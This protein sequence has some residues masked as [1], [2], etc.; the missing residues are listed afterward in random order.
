MGL[1]KYRQKRNFDQTPEPAMDHRD[2]EPALHFVIQK[3][4]ASHLHYDLRLEVDG[5]LKSWAVP[6][7]PSLDP[8]VKRLAMMVEDHPYGYKDFEG[9]IPPGNYGAGPVI[10]WDEGSCH[11][12][13]TEDRNGSEEI[14]RRGLAKGEVKFI[15]HGHK[16]RG[17]FALVKTRSAGD[18][19][20]LLIKKDDE[21]ASGEDITRLDRS[22]ISGRRVDE[23]GPEGDMPVLP[24]IPGETAMMPHRIRPMLASLIKDPFDHPDWIFEIKLDGY[25]TIAEI[26]DAVT[27][28]SRNLLPFNAKFPTIVTSLAALGREALLDGELVI[29]DEN[30]R[31]NFQLLQN[32]GRT[33]EG[34]ITFFAFDLLYLDGHDLRNLPLITRKTLLQQI[35]PDLPDVKYCD[36]LAGSGVDFFQ[37]ARLNNLEGIVAKHGNSRYETGKRSR[38]WLK[39]K[40]RL[41]QEAIICGFTAPRGSRK[42]FGALV[43][44]AYEQGKLVYIGH[45][46][47]GFDDATLHELHELLSPLVQAD[48]P[49]A[50]KVA[51]NMP[52]HWVKPLL[53]CEVEFSEWTD[54]GVMRH[55]VFLGLREDK[56]AR[57]VI[58]ES[59]TALPIDSVPGLSE[60]VSGKEQDLVINQRRL[61]LSNLD[62]VFWPEEGLTKKDVIDYYRAVAP[63][64]LSHLRD[65]PQSLYR[66]PHG[67]KEG[68]FYQKDVKDLVADWLVT[69]SI[70][71]E[72]Q[73]KSITFLLCQDEA[74][75]VY[76]AN[77]GCIE[78]NPW[79]SR[80]GTLDY[81]DYLVI[82]LDPEDIGF[83]KVIEAALA[84]KEVLDHAGARSFPKTSGA[85][86]IHIYVPLAATYDYETAGRFAHLV[87]TLARGLVPDFT[88][89][90]RSPAKRQG[91]VYLDFLQNKRGQTLAAPYSIRPRP[92]ATV[93]TP[94]DW[95]EVRPGLHPGNFTLKNVPLRLKQR[96]D[97]FSGTLGPGIQMQQC[98]EKLENF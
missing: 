39:I 85:T 2:K 21:F 75:L 93:S 76:M 32:Y 23:L 80:L 62:K 52:V 40:A 61:K 20:W 84:V 88:S 74:S 47:G 27:L 25:R 31:S 64:M 54:D 51:P 98:L 86:G 3:H 13:E 63:V 6:K 57:A 48:S 65:R 89:L 87:A 83:D 59:L 7:G 36:H 17:R 91:K 26:S 97:I 29:L 28:Y 42:K 18:N 33:G 73:N 15:L 81:P 37:E 49:F 8:A 72:S 43:L 94:L 30:G 90:E 79:L 96:G 95:S 1:E 34:S 71:S 38:E 53:V 22:V 4:N 11:A 69:E 77:L 60:E 50:T 58:R 14:F 55:P 92:G 41:S 16:V 5:V 66:T 78:I 67:I 35:L 56:E 45:S 9:I 46:G 10:I 44:G 24:D 12:Y 70:P 68:G 19:S 82:D